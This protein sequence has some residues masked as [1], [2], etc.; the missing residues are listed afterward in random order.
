MER[1]KMLLESR[2]LT[3]IQEIK[4]VRENCIFFNLIT[5]EQSEFFNLDIHVVMKTISFKSKKGKINL[6]LIEICTRS[7]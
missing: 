4:P 2:V 7:K 5:K 3:K 6:G 1:K